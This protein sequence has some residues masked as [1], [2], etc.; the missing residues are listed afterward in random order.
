MGPSRFTFHGARVTCFLGKNLK[1]TSEDF[2]ILGVRLG[3]H[4]P[5]RIFGM[6]SLWRSMISPQGRGDRT[7]MNMDSS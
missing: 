3:A 2:P 5:R 4:H 6:I 1:R 7:R